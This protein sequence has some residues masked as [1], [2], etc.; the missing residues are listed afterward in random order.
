MFKRWKM[1]VLFSCLFLCFL[2]VSLFLYTRVKK[3]GV[4]GVATKALASFTFLI[5]AIFLAATKSTLSVYS[6]YAIACLIAGL[7]CG[8]IGDVL[9]DLKVVYPYHQDKYLT[10]GMM[11]FG[12]GHFFYISALILLVQNS[13]NL[14][15]E[16]WPCLLLVLGVALLLTVIIF[17]LSKNLLKFKFEK[18]ASLVNIYTFIL[19]FTASFAIYLSFIFTALPLYML[20][21]GFLLFLLSDLV[22]SMQYFGGK[23]DNKTLIV[24]NHT[25][26][27]LA[28]IT[29]AAFIFFI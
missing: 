11:S 28:Q 14:F 17:L 24:V 15:A 5:L 3:G 13:I 1:I 27:Y 22:L 4:E 9:L 12:L 20:V 10:F 29:I 21:I 8:L 18:F 25:L 23:Q 16:K 7:V 26:Y 6:S 19:L 2:A